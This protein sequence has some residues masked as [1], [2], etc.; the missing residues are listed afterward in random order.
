MAIRRVATFTID[1]TSF[2]DGY[3]GWYVTVE[4]GGHTFNCGPDPLSEQ[5]FQKL[6]DA[7]DLIRK[8]SEDRGCEYH[9]PLVTVVVTKHETPVVDP[10]QMA[11]FVDKASSPLKESA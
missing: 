2:E 10:N 9:Q 6:D 7:L 1:W 8:W 4:T 3:E 5:G 11:L